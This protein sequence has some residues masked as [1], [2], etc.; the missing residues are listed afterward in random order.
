MSDSSN[1]TSYNEVVSNYTFGDAGSVFSNKSRNRSNSSFTY[2]VNK[3]Y[4]DGRISYSKIFEK[5]GKSNVGEVTEIAYPSSQGIMQFP[6]EG[7]PIDIYFAPE[8]YSLSLNK[9][10]PRM[11]AYWKSTNGSLNI[12]EQGY[13]TTNNE[14]INNKTFDPSVPSYAINNNMNNITVG[15]MQN[16]LNGFV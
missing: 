14:P 10:A 15:N 11:R 1:F 9:S 3:V 12:W 6:E 2:Q 16:A 7:E 5:F 13:E 8:P 4:P